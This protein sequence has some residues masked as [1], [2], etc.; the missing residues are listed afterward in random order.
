MLQFRRAALAA[1]LSFL[2]LAAA[3]PASAAEDV[4]TCP[5]GVA[6]VVDATEL[7][8]DVSVGCADDSPATGTDALHQAGFTDTRDGSGLICAIDALPD[9]CPATFEGSY[10]SYWYVADGEWVSYMEGSD[11]AVPGVADGWRWGD[12]S[13]P[14]DVAPA[15]L[16]ATSTDDPSASPSASAS[17]VAASPSAS[18]EPSV[19]EATTDVADQGG[20]STGGW[21]VIGI[22]ALVVAVV[23]VVATALVTRRRR[24]V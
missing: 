15:D 23:L 6:V 24:D 11:T 14:P 9:P 1:A 3:L 19:N 16:V 5:D 7:D 10:W 22:V 20:T 18:E 12:G 17:A 13:T 4:T 21:P 8:G 2:P